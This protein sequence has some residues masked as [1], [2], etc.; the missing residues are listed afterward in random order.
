MEAAPRNTEN[1]SRSPNEAHFMGATLSQ[2]VSQGVTA[3]EG[4]QG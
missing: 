2:V 1:V 4:S 3:G